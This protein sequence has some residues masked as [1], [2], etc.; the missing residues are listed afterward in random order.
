MKKKRL[1]A[2]KRFI[3]LPDEEKDAE[4]AQYENG[5]DPKDWHPLTP[6]QRKQWAR[7]KRKSDR[8]PHRIDR[9]RLPSC[10]ANRPQCSQAH[11]PAR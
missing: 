9:V 2:I 1:S 6:A 8:P 10:I 7:I 3:A 4:V 5:T 11:P